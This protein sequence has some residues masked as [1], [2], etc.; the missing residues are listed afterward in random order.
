MGSSGVSMT[1]LAI[2]GWTC[3]WLLGFWY[4][5][6]LVMGLYRA[7]LDKR[8]TGPMLWL[9]GPAL[10]VGY[11]VDL[12]SNWTL[13]SLFFLEPPRRPL[14]LVTDRLTRHIQTGDG[15]R[16]DFAKSICVNLLDFFDPS[17]KHCR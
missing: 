17:G 6:V 5:Y 10:V 1:P 11:A 15:W 14:E 3:L 7:H 4:L 13:A 9:A 2:L 8:L 12:V 16:H